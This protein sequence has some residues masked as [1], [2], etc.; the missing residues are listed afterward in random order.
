MDNDAI[1]PNDSTDYAAQSVSYTGTAG[2]VTGF[3]A[4]PRQVLV[5]TTSDAHVKV[6]EGV[7]ATTASCPIPAYTPIVMR[8]PNGSGG[9]WKVSAIQVAAGGT[10]Y[11]KPLG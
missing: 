6:G 3:K 8:V 7:T 11:A 2:T 9:L 4:G 1:Y 10:L 5:W